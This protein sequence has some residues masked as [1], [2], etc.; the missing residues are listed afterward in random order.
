[1]SRPWT[2]RECQWLLQ[3]YGT[4][5]TDWIADRLGRSRRAIYMQARSL[6]LHRPRVALSDTTIEQALRKHNPRGL[7]DAQIANLLESLHGVAVDRQQP[8]RDLTSTSKM[9]KPKSA[10]PYASCC[11]LVQDKK[12]GKIALQT[13]SAK[14]VA[15][16]LWGKDV[17]QW[18][19]YKAVRCVSANIAEIEHMLEFR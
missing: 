10:N 15:L 8:I 3:W 17:R 12:S 18:T 13:D 9:T 14:E 1:M 19:M 4:R 2:K 5:P 16:W 11:Y 6:Q 7:P